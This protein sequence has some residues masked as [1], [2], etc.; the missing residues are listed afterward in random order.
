M[1][2]TEVPENF[3]HN[4][5]ARQY[6]MRRT[7]N[8]LIFFSV[9]LL[10]PVVFLW[11]CGVA[12][13]S[14]GSILALECGLLLA[15]GIAPYFEHS[16]IP[17]P[18]PIPF[19]GNMLEHDI[20]G[21]HEYYRRHYRKF[22]D[23]HKFVQGRTVSIVLNNVDLVNQMFIKGF[24]NFTNRPLPPSMMG[25]D[26]NGMI[27]ARDEKWKKIRRTCAP[28]F[29]TKNLRTFGPVMNDAATTL[30]E[31]LDAASK[32]KE[33]INIWRYWGG[34]T[35]EVIGST[36][37]GVKFA[38]QSGKPDKMT[39]AAEALFKFSNFARASVGRFILSVVP[40]VMPVLRYMPNPQIK[41]L[42]ESIGLLDQTSLDLI[43]NR[44][45]DPNADRHN[46]LAT[47]LIKATDNVTGDALS[48][49]DIRD[50]SNT[51][52]LAGYETTANTLSFCT[53][54]I[55]VNPDVQ[56][57]MLEEIDRF[58]DGKDVNYD[59]LSNYVYLEALVKESQRMYPAVAAMS[60]E[61]GADTELGGVVFKKGTKFVIPSYAFHYDSQHWENPNE[62][63]PER[64][65]DKDGNLVKDPPAFMPFGSGPRIC[66][67]WRFAL[68][69]VKLAIVRIYREYTFKL[70]EK[71]LVPLRLEPGITMAPANSEILMT[72]ERRR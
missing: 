3:P 41:L 63:I 33:V 59:D 22:G 18:L 69:E 64:F 7:V 43:A 37:F 36:S 19:F 29:S 23:M 39:D 40:F 27:F 1:T 46:D 50:Q 53:Y 44:R 47:L 65:L 2:D 48:D 56:K 58:N 25:R 52:L 30:A 31:R 17:G 8:T 13:E 54:C 24:S 60:R 67:G 28:I 32:S 61:A 66:I 20:I 16:A 9:I 51:F 34:M 6:V 49:N 11:A 72:V 45:S 57:K 4:V 14:L 10:V 62:F 42:M 38:S 12:V 35:L 26:R 21:S 5:K 55:T 70:S 71:Q 68:E 15:W